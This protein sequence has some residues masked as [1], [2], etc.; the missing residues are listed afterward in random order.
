MSTASVY[1]IRL[2]EHSNIFCDGYVGVTKNTKRRWNQHV[3]AAKLNKHENEH[4]NFAILKYGWDNLIKEVVLVAEESYC[5]KIEGKIREKEQIGWNINSGGNKPPVAK[6]R[7]QN[8]V[9][10]LKGKPRATPW[11]IGKI[12][13]KEQREQISKNRKIKVKYQNVVYQSLEDL[14]KHLNVKYSTLTNR[15]YRNAKKWGYEVLK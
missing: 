12:L 9:S 11:L 5:Y 8:Y 2:K 6:H 3:S 13:S 14:A 15:I 4:L 1:W 10:P 7:G